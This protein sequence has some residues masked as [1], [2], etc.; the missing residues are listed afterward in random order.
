M[1]SIFLRHHQVGSS[2]PSMGRRDRCNACDSTGA[3]AGLMSQ[4]PCIEPA[5]AMTHHCNRLAI[6][7]RLRSQEINRPDQTQKHAL[8]VDFLPIVA[9]GMAVVPQ[10]A[11]VLLL[12][13]VT[14]LSV[15][16]AVCIDVH[17]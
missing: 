11:G 15:G 6:P 5:L 1:A 13:E 14:G 10:R 12:V 4:A 17:G 8:E 9:T 3:E 16:Q 7:F 2:R